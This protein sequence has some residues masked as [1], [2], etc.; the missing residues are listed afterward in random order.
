MYQER[1]NQTPQLVYHVVIHGKAVCMP[2]HWG[3]TFAVPESWVILHTSNPSHTLNQVKTTKIAFDSTLLDGGFSIVSTNHPSYIKNDT[4]YLEIINKATNQSYNPRL[5]HIGL[6]KKPLV[7]GNTFNYEVGV[8]QTPWSADQPAVCSFNS[9][10]F[11]YPADFARVLAAHAGPA[12]SHAS[13]ELSRFTGGQPDSYPEY[14]NLFTALERES[15]KGS[16]VITSKFAKELIPVLGLSLHKVRSSKDVFR[17]ALERCSNTRFNTLEMA[18]FK[19]PQLGTAV[20]KAFGGSK[21]TFLGF[22]G[23]AAIIALLYAAG[24]VESGLQVHTSFRT[25]GDNH[26]ASIDIS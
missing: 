26:I 22:E 4:L 18:D 14:D 15:N 8:I 25:A 16:T 7:A 1:I 24:A 6:R 2:D 10:K 12:R 23:R 21:A 13:L 3:N 9:R 20:W 19:G 11:K 5:H 17:M